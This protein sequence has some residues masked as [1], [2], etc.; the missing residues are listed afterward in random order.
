[1]ATLT[2]P[3]AAT[4]GGDLAV[5]D[6]DGEITWAELDERVN[7]LVHSLRDAG[8]TATNTVAV[9]AGNRRE[10]IEMAMACAHGGWTYV[11]VNWHWVAD[12]LAYVFADA[13]VK[14]V[15]VDHRYAEPVGR[16]LADERSAGVRLVAGI[17]TGAEVGALAPLETDGRFIEYEALV[18]RGRTDE[19]REQRL[20]G[21]MFYTSGTTGRPKGVRGMLSGNAELTPDIMQLIAAGFAD[22][23]PIP[24]CTLLC[25]P[26]YH[27][28]QWAFSYLPMIGGSSVIMQHKYDSAGVLELIDRHRVTNVH[29]VPTQ[30]KRLVDLPDD[31]RESFDGSSL[32]AVWHGAAPCPPQVKRALIDWWGPKI[33]EYYGSTEGS[34][35]S[36]ITSADWL[37]KGGSVGKPVDMVEV[38]VVD[39]DGNRITEPNVEGTLYFR[40]KMGTDFAYHNDA[41]KTAAAHLEPG[42]FTTGD[43]GYLDADGDLWLSDRRI[44][45]IISGG[46]NIYPAEIE[47]VLGGHPSVAD[48]AV[49]GVPDEEYGERVTAIVQPADGVVGTDELAAELIAYCRE[50]L[51]GYKAPRSIDFIGAMPRTGSG[52]LQKQ[53]LRA[54]YWEGRDRKI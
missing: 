44:D 35:I 16:A 39:D 4:R 8:L 48:V 17:A 20:G 5:V 10:W 9:V 18:R 22:Y 25:G 50:H 6:E 33:T 24:G 52:K 7:R 19:P 45:M 21:P 32:V 31:V 54:P 15:V 23:L 30:M 40:N 36:T 41:E 43:V 51:A 3:H 34:I 11:P 46:V 1:V 49:I 14:A 29:L 13:G 28:A 26:F 2:A 38:I 37:A 53:P 42:V 27:S 12:E 47:G